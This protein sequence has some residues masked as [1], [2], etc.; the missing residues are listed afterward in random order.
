MGPFFS[1]PWLNQP[2]VKVKFRFFRRTRVMA[3]S[4]F[5][6]V[7]VRTHIVSRYERNTKVPV[8]FSCT[9]KHVNE[10]SYLTRPDQRTIKSGHTLTE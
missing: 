2:H 6:S 10:K 9:S 5:L 4:N 1:S 7:L 3:F 8:D